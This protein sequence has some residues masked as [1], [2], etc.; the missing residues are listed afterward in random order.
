MELGNR[1]TMAYTVN[2]IQLSNLIFLEQLEK[3]SRPS[4]EEYPKKQMRNAFQ[5]LFTFKF[6][7]FLHI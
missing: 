4:P 1:E 3:I 6:V 2:E 5:S 7:T